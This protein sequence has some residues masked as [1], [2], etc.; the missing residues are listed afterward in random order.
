MSISVVSVKQIKEW[1]KMIFFFFFSNFLSVAIV[2][3]A[4]SGLTM[5]LVRAGQAHQ[6]AVK[7]M[8]QKSAPSWME[9]SGPCLEGQES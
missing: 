8:R 5:L 3:F 1:E 9:R 6:Q 2:L 7:T 4:G